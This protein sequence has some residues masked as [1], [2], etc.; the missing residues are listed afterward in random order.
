MGRSVDSKAL[1]TLAGIGYAGLRGRR[2]GWF[3]PE[4]TDPDQA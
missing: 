2:R 1:S 4:M 3:A